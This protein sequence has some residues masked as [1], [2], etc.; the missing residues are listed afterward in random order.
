MS[1]ASRRRRTR[2]ACAPLI[3][4]V[5]DSTAEVCT[6]RQSHTPWMQVNVQRLYI[7]SFMTALNMAGL[8]LSVLRLDDGRLQRLDAPT[9]V[10][11]K[12]SLLQLIIYVN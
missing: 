9:K 11:I 10:Y 6:L 3:N 1:G 5:V 8:S 4:S 2:Q 7:G 12:P